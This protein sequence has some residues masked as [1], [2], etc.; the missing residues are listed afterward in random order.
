MNDNKVL[1]ITGM[2][3]S[4]TSLLTQ[5]LQKCGLHIGDQLL[6]ASTGNEEGHYEDLDF[7]ECHKRILVKNKYHEDG[8]VNLTRLQPPPKE[9]Q[10]MRN[11]VLVKNAMRAQW[12]WKDPRTCLLLQEY[13]TIIPDAFYLVI[14]RDYQSVV[15]SLISRTYNET[16]RKYGR[17]KGI[18][19]FIWDKFGKPYRKENLLKKYSEHYVKVWIAYNTAI[20]EHLQAT[21]PDH[22]LVVDH[23]NLFTDNE[24]VFHHLE[25]KWGFDLNYVDFNTIYKKQLLSNVLDIGA[26]VNDKSL[27]KKAADLQQL[28]IS[29][30]SW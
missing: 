12:G 5:W 4:G 19:H 23:A 30:G 9:A 18:K 6:G 13:R 3:R 21:D 16:A 25:N 1:V 27:L 24:E 8:F 20:L 7:Y 29:Y 17:K 2:H 28:L 11:M 14:L 15:S 26:Y 22:Y 10:L